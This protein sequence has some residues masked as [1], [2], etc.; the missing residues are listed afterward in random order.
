MLFFCT[1]NGRT[2]EQCLLISHCH[3]TD[4]SQLYRYMLY[5][6]IHIA[7]VFILLFAFSSYFNFKMAVILFCSLEHDVVHQH[8]YL[9]R[10]GSRTGCF[11]KEANN[12]FFQCYLKLYKQ[13]RETHCLD[14][15]FFLKKWWLDHFSNT[16]KSKHKGLRTCDCVCQKSIMIL[17]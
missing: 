16:E 7:L 1:G 12:V 10:L 6:F 8:R 4:Q 2:S 11:S 17:W 15:F 13:C 5:R 3:H 9:F 14:F